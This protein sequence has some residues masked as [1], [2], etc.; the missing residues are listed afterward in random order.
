MNTG[1]F[2]MPAEWEPHEAV[3]LGWEADSSYGFYPVIS[4]IIKTLTP[5]VTVKMAFHSDSLLRSAR[6]YLRSKN[7][8]TTNIRFYVMPGE[9]YWIM[10]APFL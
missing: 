7:V 1:N 3:W 10:G 9:R 4:E 2:Y 6:L 8:D 5:N